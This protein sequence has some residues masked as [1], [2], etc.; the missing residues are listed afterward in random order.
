VQVVLVRRLP[1]LERPQRLVLLGQLRKAAQDEVE[2]DRD[3]LL[4][5]ERAVVVEDRD[6]LLVRKALDGALGERDDR[7]A[8]G[9]VMPGGE[10]LRHPGIIP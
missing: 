8:R 1:G 7:L 10:G 9:R 5:P 4:A 3:G 2:L 6:P